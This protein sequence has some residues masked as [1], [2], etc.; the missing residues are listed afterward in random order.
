MNSSVANIGEQLRAFRKAKKLSQAKLGTMAGLSRNTIMQI[1]KGKRKSVKPDLLR[2]V[3]AVLEI[4]ERAFYQAL[5]PVAEATEQESADPF[6]LVVLQDVLKQ[7]DTVPPQYRSIVRQFMTTVMN[8]AVKM[9]V[10]TDT[11]EGAKSNDD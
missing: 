10:S 6:S 8:E 5:V 2:Q 3:A 9:I 7:L 4:D 1:E 11:T